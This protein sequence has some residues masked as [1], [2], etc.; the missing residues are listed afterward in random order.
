MCNADVENWHQGSRGRNLETPE[1]YSCC[2]L[3]QR[4][5]TG[6]IKEQDLQQAA[7]LS[8]RREEVAVEVMGSSGS[9]A[10]GEAAN[11][12]VVGFDEEAET[13]PPFLAQ[14]GV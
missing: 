11:K 4:P 3:A 7:N 12:G 8:H 5:P 10:V 2:L 13:P 1:T 6:I 14:G 9:A